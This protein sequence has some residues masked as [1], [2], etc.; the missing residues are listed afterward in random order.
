MNDLQ[1][2]RDAFEAPAPTGRARARAA[3]LEAT[4]PRRRPLLTL[5]RFALAGVALALALGVGVGARNGG[6][7]SA[8]ALERAADAA[9]RQPFT[10]PRDDQWIYTADQ[11]GGATREEWRR[12]DG[13]GFALRHGNG[14]LHVETA[15]RDSEAARKRLEAVAVFESYKGLA[16][17]PTHPDALLRWAY[18]QTDSISGAGSTP[19][20][21]VYAIFR[22]LIGR[23]VLPPDLHAAIFRAIKQ[24]P[25]V[26]LST[27]D[28]LGDHARARTH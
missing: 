23:G 11:L 17:L 7:A 21:E 6:D 3:L 2:L 1:I 4:A 13:G 18:D 10:A 27:T 16:T 14:K 15:R 28:V 22:G 24:I 26:Q 25:G 5:R 12:A 19:D 8:E 9:E 20:A